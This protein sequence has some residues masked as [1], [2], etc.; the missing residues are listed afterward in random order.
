ME[1]KICNSVIVFLVILWSQIL[2]NKKAININAGLFSKEP[3]SSIPEPKKVFIPFWQFESVSLD[4][5]S[6]HMPCPQTVRSHVPFFG[7]LKKQ[8]D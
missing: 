1:E 3:H 5:I 7:A 6:Q 8:T 4:A 2:Q